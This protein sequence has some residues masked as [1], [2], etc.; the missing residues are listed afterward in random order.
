MSSII[1]NS[2][3]VYSANVANH[4]LSKFI[5]DPYEYMNIFAKRFKTL[6]IYNNEFRNLIINVLLMTYFI[7]N[8]ILLTKNEMITKQQDKISKLEKEVNVNYID[9]SE[10]CKL[11]DEY[12]EQCN[13]LNKKLS[14]MTIEYNKLKEQQNLLTKNLQSCQ[15]KKKQIQSKYDKLVYNNKVRRESPNDFS[16]YVSKRKKT[17]HS[18][19]EHSL[20]ESSYETTTCSLP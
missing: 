15:T 2:T 19:E 8:F 6:L 4:L 13:K 17:N 12:S 5:N 20:I 18:D 10:M 9:I 3:L 11:I 7:Y 1:V 16:N 14:D